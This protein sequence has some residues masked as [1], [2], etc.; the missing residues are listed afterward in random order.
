MLA[1]QRDT[2]RPLRPGQLHQRFIAQPDTAAY[3]RRVMQQRAQ[4]RG[5]AAAVRADNRQALPA[6]DRKMNIG[7]QRLAGVMR[8]V[9]MFYPQ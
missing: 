8:H 1:H 9:Q 5:F 4:Q 2:P 3:R 6:P 7:K